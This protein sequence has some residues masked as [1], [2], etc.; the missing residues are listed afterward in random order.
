MASGSAIAGIL[1]AAGTSSRM[2]QNKM[3]L[4]FA[5]DSVLRGGARRAL[6]GGLSPLI[7]VLGAEADRAAAE[8][9]GLP[10]HIVQNRKYASGMTSSMH[11]GL[12]ALPPA[13]GAAV[14]L[15]ADMPLVTADMIRQ[16]TQRYQETGA[17]LVISRYA[18]VNAP[19]TLF[20]RCLF[21]E[22]LASSGE[23]AGRQVVQRHRAAAEVL[24]WPAAVLADLDTPEDYTRLTAR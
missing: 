4:A 8:L 3:L 19:P 20:D 22:L 18:G 24:D 14:I 21:I 17:P 11:A 16:M 15:L 12:T 13:T 6:A 5:G 23:D 2:G 9:D 7:V 10:C 1:L